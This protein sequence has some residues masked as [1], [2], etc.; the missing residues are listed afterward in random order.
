MVQEVVRD[1]GTQV[2]VAVE[3]DDDP[4]I[5]ALQ[6]DPEL[7]GRVN[8]MA[9]Q[10]GRWVNQQ[11][12]ATNTSTAFD[13]GAFITPNNP[14]DQ[15]RMGRR[16]VRDDDVVST[17]ADL[18]QAM[19]LQ[20]VKWESAD[21]DETDV[22]NQ[23]AIEM[24]LDT[25]LR[26]MWREDFGTSQVTLAFWW[27]EGTFR[28]RGKT[29]VEYEQDELTGSAKV[30]PETGEKVVKKKATRRKKEI[31]CTYPRFVSI[32]DSARVVP[33]GMMAFGQERLAWQASVQELDTYNQVL[34]GNVQDDLM[35][36]YY[37][38]IYKVS[39]QD[40][41]MEL[42][43]MRVDPNRLVLLN[44][45]CV[46]RL[47]FD[48]P[49]YARFA[50]V[51]LKSV[52]R[53]LDLKQQLMDADRVSLVGAANYILLIKKGS[54]ADPGQPEEITNIRE[55][56]NTVAKL[57]VIFSD[58]RLSIEI[59]TPKTDFT[60]DPKKYDMIDARILAKLMGMLTATNVSETSS[61]GAD[62]LKYARSIERALENRRHM[63]RRFLEKEIARAIVRHP[64][65]EGKF[66]DEPNLTFIPAKIHLDDDTGFGQAVLEL[67]SM[68]ELS[69]ETVLEYFDF[70]QQVE[71]MRR[72]FEKEDG[73]DDIFET[74]V[75]FSSPM[76][77][78]A[79]GQPG[80]PVVGPDGNVPPAASRGAGRQGG[81]PTGGGKTAQSPGKRTAKKASGTK[82]PEGS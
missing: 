28:V 80:A 76:L 9:R 35:S 62:V 2:S 38:N 34:A 71:A 56:W 27:D 77:G 48:R 66:T 59:I 42:S 39:D 1:V 26:K 37:E 58:H 32:L 49:D 50:D 64:A 52:F 68:N 20:G 81:R 70:D 4:Y 16:A 17:A 7:T 10:L 14:L 19:A 6:G 78:G 44:P 8:T 67:R 51:R 65:N 12:A 11:R 5:R 61:A 33:V 46:K 74:Q 69:R 25:L 47:S 72:T 43:N 40:E 57:P 36:R 31:T 63:L 21:R 60:L 3:W 53:L 75:P 73:Y 15:M 54:D 29:G 22:F 41:Q 18:T 82:S 24:D 23:I 45:E 30:D 55:N 13:K 79:D